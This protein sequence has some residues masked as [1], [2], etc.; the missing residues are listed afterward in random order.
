MCVVQERLETEIKE[1]QGPLAE[2]SRKNR[3]FSRDVRDVVQAGDID[4]A[5]EMCEDQVRTLFAH[6]R[7]QACGFASI[8][9]CIHSTLGDFYDDHF[10]FPHLLIE[11]AAWQY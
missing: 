1:L 10:S 7:Q 8:L 4:R 6:A 5:R 9:S 11:S 2:A 3:K